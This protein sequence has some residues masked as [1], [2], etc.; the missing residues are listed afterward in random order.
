M[1]KELVPCIWVKEACL[2]RQQPVDMCSLCERPF[3]LFNNHRHCSYCGRVFHRRDCSASGLGRHR[4]CTHCDDYRS[5]LRDKL[6]NG[7]P[8]SVSL[9]IIPD[10]YGD[11]NHEVAV[12]WVRVL[13]YNRASLNAH[14]FSSVGPIMFLANGHGL[15]SKMGNLAHSKVGV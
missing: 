2:F 11:Y 5:M 12:M 1:P 6:S 10:Y 14:N 15:F 4:A 9:I 3:T 7:E 13:A 8:L